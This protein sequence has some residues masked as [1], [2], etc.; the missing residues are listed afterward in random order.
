MPRAAVRTC[1]TP[2]A[3]GT[4]LAQ[5]I[6]DRVAAAHAQGH[7]FLLGVPTGRTPKPIFAAMAQQL[8][9]QPQSLRHVTLVMMDEYLVA[10]EHGMKYAPREASWSCHHF[11]RVEILARLNRVLPPDDQLDDEKIWFPLPHDPGEYESRIA[12]A[13]GIDFFL[14][15]S[16]AHD[17]HVAFNPPG[18][19]RDSHTRIIPLSEATRRDNLQSFPSFGALEHVPHHGVSVGVATILAAREAV[20]VAWG[21]GKRTTVARMASADRYAPSWP[22]TLIHECARGEIVVDEAAAGHT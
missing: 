22:A 20:M 1:T 8:A 3:L 11:A 18:S 12:A 5:Q 7:H 4:S 21:E 9:E 13:G 10:G 15:A 16:G 14:L 2:E 19:T 6:L 17:G